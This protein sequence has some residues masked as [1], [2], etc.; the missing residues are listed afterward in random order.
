[1]E[2]VLEVYQRRYHDDFPVVCV[3]EAMK[4][5]VKET[6]APIAAQRKSTQAGRLQIRAQWNRESVHAV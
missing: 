1:M 4:Q 6:I 3:D 2:T 5:L